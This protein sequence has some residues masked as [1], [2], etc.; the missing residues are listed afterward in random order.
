MI[1]RSSAS[2]SWPALCRPRRP[3]HTDRQ[4]SPPPGKVP[5]E[6]I[7]GHKAKQ[8]QKT[9]Q[10]WEDGGSVCSW[11]SLSRTRFSWKSFSKVAENCLLV[12]KKLGYSYRKATKGS[13]KVARRAG[14]N[15][16]ATATS[17]R[18]SATP[19]NVRG[20]YALTPYRKLLNRRVSANAARIPTPTPARANRKPSPTTIRKTSSGC[21]PSVTR[22]PISLVRCVTVYDMT[23]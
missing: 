3:S 11:R 2:E 7:Q 12:T 22:I 5:T 21:A 19:P 6:S 17:V 18:I 23:P 15:D 20:S 13:T 14:K 8:E 4:S 9:A 1:L 10:G 16:A